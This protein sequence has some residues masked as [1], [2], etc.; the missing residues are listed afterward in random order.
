M[1]KSTSLETIEVPIRGMCCADEAQQVQRAIAALPG[2]ESCE[3][4][5]AADKAVLRCDPSRV[6]PEAI[7]E[8]VRL[9]G[10]SVPVATERSHEF[11]A[12]GFGRVVLTLFGAVFAVV[13]LVV[14]LGEWLGWLDAVTDRVPWPVWLTLVL[15]GGYPVFR[16]VLRAALRRQ[17]T[18]HT[19]MTAGVIA[20]VAVHEWAAALVVVLFMRIADYIEG[21]TTQ[22]A[23]RALRD[24]AA[25][26][27]RVARVDRDGAEIEVPVEELRPGHVVVVRPGGQVP[28][29]GEV[30]SGQATVD[31][32]AITGESMPVE[33]E[34]GTT[35][36]AASVVRLGML[37][38]RATRI[39]AD[40]TFGR[41][42]RLVEEAEAHRAEVQRTAD[43]FAT[44]YLPVVLTIAFL[45]FLI[46]RNPLAAAAVL[47][48]ACSCAFAIATP[49]AMLA[50]IGHAARRGLVIKGGKYVEA[51]ARADVLLL[52][53]T[54]TLTL[55][56]PRITDV[57]SLN[58]ADPDDVLSLAAS[59]ERYSEHPLAEAVRVLASERG[60]RLLE[61]EEFQA[62]PG[63]GVK[64]EVNGRWV[65]VGRRPAETEATVGEIAAL[66]AQ[67]K[68][69]L[70]VARDGDP[71]GVLAAADTLRPEVPEAI[72]S[73][74]A[75]GLTH[76]ELLTG[77]HERAAASLATPL[78]IAYRAGLLP[79]DKIAVVKA[80]QTRGHRVVMVGDGVNDAPA[81]AQADVGVAMG[82]AGTDIAM[83]AAH[84]VLMRDDWCLVPDLFRIAKR[85][86]G[87]V[88]LN[89]GFTAAY[90]L[91]GLSLA[92]LGLLPLVLAAAV[93]SLP[94][95]GI[96]ANSS[97]LLRTDRKTGAPAAAVTV[98]RHV[99]SAS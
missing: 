48:V 79:E 23:R 87:V 29:D 94:D 3:V 40:T 81:L 31:Q 59:A 67:G 92:A 20:A 57:V 11:R 72:A 91:V 93:Q 61:P 14:V 8:A 99:E 35:V 75:L 73:L 30:V 24:L 49:V 27:P 96:M 6:A 95:L 63:V 71:L 80:Y 34:Q 70:F 39:G 25:M 37:R 17:V 15:A 86:M 28:V 74:W 12:G 83:E 43:R 42:V 85:T 19:L 97:R 21:F 41:V 38:V 22:R 54:G 47:V 62:V 4:L 51:L 58:G 68:A 82:A 26:A 77:D 98:H 45:T 1:A 9:T 78:G 5:L 2:V 84:V 89:I 64:A 52:D 7:Q 16:G 66:E 46:G 76:I 60:L 69:L 18:A 53:K 36:F 88:R 90:N 55:G 56:R 13:L 50:S 10:C 44:W 32:A 33:A 65:T